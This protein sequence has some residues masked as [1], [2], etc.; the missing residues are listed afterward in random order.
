MMP[1]VTAGLLAAA[2]GEAEYNVVLI[3]F[4]VQPPPLVP[5]LLHPRASDLT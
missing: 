2:A 3:S 5:Q 4:T 1:T